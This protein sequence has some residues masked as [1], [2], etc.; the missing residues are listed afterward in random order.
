MTP[1]I[2]LDAQKLSS[3]YLT[4]TRVD[5][6]VDSNGSGRSV[7]TP[8][9]LGTT[10][11]PTYDSALFGGKG[12][13]TFGS[14]SYLESP[15]AFPE[16]D[17]RRG[18]TILI[19]GTPKS[20][21]FAMS[22]ASL[23][24]LGA[25]LGQRLGIGTYGNSWKGL[26]TTTCVFGIRWDCVKFDFILNGEIFPV[27]QGSLSAGTGAF[28]KLQLGGI[29]G[30]GGNMQMDVAA[31][32]IWDAP[33]EDDEIFSTS[34]SLS[35]MREFP[36]PIEEPPYNIVVDGNSLAVG[37][38]SD[39][40]TTMWDGVNG[41]TGTTP[42]DLINVASSGLETPSMIER[43]AKTAFIHLNLGVPSKRR[44][45]IVWEISNDLANLTQTDVGAYANIKS[46]CQAATTAGFEVIVCTCLPRTQSGINPNFETYRNSVNT[47]VNANAV[48]EGWA[49][50]VADIG[51]DTTIGATGASNNTTYYNGD[52]IHLTSAGH[53]I[54]AGYITTAL[55]AIL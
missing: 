49:I 16:L 5:Q 34:N 47:S 13:I 52:K 6:W 37:G 23:I 3:L 1:F 44:I 21:F 46:Y 19:A 17:W 12:G 43:A 4:G 22:D 31:I 38:I 41:I 15:A 33:I 35:I 48:S 26:P 50:A 7:E 14:P 55:A 10:Y 45:L 29:I 27:T 25:G 8:V 11:N 36:P 40:H 32:K 39:N 18:F 42:L 20:G 2:F 54:A 53:F 51:G 24:L 30:A 28:G 9:S